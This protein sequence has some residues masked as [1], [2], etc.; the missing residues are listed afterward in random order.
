MKRQ[1]IKFIILTCLLIL[2]FCLNGCGNHKKNKQA[3]VE[4]WHNARNNIALELAGKQVQNGQIE[5]A[6]Q[7]IQDSLDK[8]PDFIGGWLMLA[9]LYQ[10]K[11]MPS[12]SQACLN[13]ALRIKPEHPE[14]NYQMALTMEMAE[15]FD[16]ALAHYETAIKYSPDNLE[17]TLARVNLLTE[18]GQKEK[19]A[20]ILQEQI[21]LGRNNPAVFMM[22][23]N[24]YTENN[25]TAQ[26]TVMYQ[27]AL[28]QEP[29]N[30]IAANKLIMSLIKDNSYPA[31][32]EEINKQQINQKR[33]NDPFLIL[34]L[35]D[36]YLATGQMIMSQRCYETLIRD[37]GAKDEY[38]IRLAQVAVA[39]NDLDRAL[40]SCNRILQKT[41]D[42]NE[43]SL[44][45]AVIYLK[46]E[47][48]SF[49]RDLSREV[50]RKNPNDALAWCILGRS[51]S[52][53]GELEK[54]Q[55]CY[56]KAESL[57]PD[58]SLTSQLLLEVEQLQLSE[59]RTNGKVENK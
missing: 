24:I 38:L 37:F 46:K 43:A 11:D 41:P 25:Q 23:G 12:A 42:N 13:Q 56:N 55:E 40:S 59:N 9:Q 47:Q 45:L 36:C 34:A 18:M 22:M 4:H 39:R 1:N 53:L 3:S 28:K 15:D 7:T 51:Q 32:I 33:D 2:S 44:L 19:A 10:Q 54:A 49:S 30:K 20:K 17:Y 5:K 14:A 58:N 8:S 27:M 57:N 16:N 6:I 26:A 35:G 52:G 48:Y 50:I 21:D 31:A 29:T